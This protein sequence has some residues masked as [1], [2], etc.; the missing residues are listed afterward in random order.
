MAAITK[1]LKEPKPHIA[2]QR[3][4]VMKVQLDDFKQRYLSIH[5]YEIA[6]KLG[7]ASDNIKEV[8][9]ILLRG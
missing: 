9:G 7:T 4:A 3:L 2:V 6:G 8:I 5:Q 1:R